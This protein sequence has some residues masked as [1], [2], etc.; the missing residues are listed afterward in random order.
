MPLELRSPTPAERPAMAEVLGHAFAV[1][2]EDATGWFDKAGNRHLRAWFDGDELVGGLLSLPMGQHVLGKAA[3][4]LGVAGVAIRADHRRRGH[5]A[6]MMRALLEEAH[7][8]GF[9]WSTLYASSY[10]LYRSVGYEAAGTRYLARVA[11]DRVGLGVRST[12]ITALP[13]DDPRIEACHRAV[14]MHRPGWLRR[15]P[16]LWRRTRS[17]GGTACHALGV[18]GDEPGKL[19]G[20]VVYAKK[21]RDDGWQTLEITDLAAHTPEAI[22][23]IWTAVADMGSMVREVRFHTAPNDPFLLA[24]P[25]PPAVQ[26][27]LHEHWMVRIVD[28]PRAIRSRGWSELCQGRIGFEVDDPHLFVNSGP[29]TIN[30]AGGRAELE[31]GGT[32]E[33]RLH[34]RGLAALMTGFADADLL[35]VMGLVSGPSAAIH[36]FCGLFAAPSP[37]LRLMF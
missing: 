23:R 28:L 9:A 18:L 14:A 24:L 10:G 32:P 4:T 36:R 19:A 21:S 11:P 34:I 12:D 16:Y 3:A 6:A 29:W 37:W 13:V 35:D 33:V 30:V 27:Q 5:G 2:P 22:A 15:T 31:R 7:S 26:V 8:R 1:P 20:Y 17:V 25:Y